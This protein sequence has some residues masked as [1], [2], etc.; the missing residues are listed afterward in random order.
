MVKSQETMMS[1]KISELSQNERTCKISYGEET[2]EVVYRP[3]AYTPELEASVQQAAEKN[4][5]G[6]LLV[7][8]LSQLI[9]HW[10]VIDEA[11]N[12]L[13]PTSENLGKLPM[14][15]LAEVT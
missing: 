6:R 15:F 5:P 1:I 13:V 10:D 12:E 11:G 9:H 2:A 4:L 14:E 8:M 7:A 3:S